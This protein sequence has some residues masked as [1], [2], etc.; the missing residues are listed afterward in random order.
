MSRLSARVLA[1]V[2]LFVSFATAGEISF[3]ED[4]SLAPDRS[5]PLKTLIPGT[6]DFFFFHSLDLQNRQR[7]EDVDAV[8]ASWLKKTRTP[9]ALYREIENR[10]HLL[11]YA[12]DPQRTLTFLRRRL[13]AV[14]SHQRPNPAAQAQLP[15]RLDPQLISVA[16]LTNR[17]L[18]R[19]GSL[20][21]IENAGLE[22]L[23]AA[24]LTDSQRRAWL[25]RLTRPDVP[26]IVRLIV[27]D[28]D[29]PGSRGFGSLAIH[30]RL[31]LKQLDECLTFRR[32]LLNEGIFVSTYI[33]KLRPG[34]DSDWR[35]ERAA[36]TAYLDSLWRFVGRL[37]PVHNSLKAHVLHRRL[38]LDHAHAQHDR[39][40]FLEYLKLPRNMPYV[41]PE[42]LKRLA[43]RRHLANL[44]ANYSAATALPIVGNDE[45]L[46]RAYLQSFFL[47]E[48]NYEVYRP[49]LSDAYLKQLFAETKIVSGQGDPSRWAALLTPE[50]YRRLQQRVDLDF[51]AANTR[52]FAPDDAVAFELDV[53]NVK[54]LIV[55]IFEINS[56]NYYRTQ[57]RELNTDINLDGLVPNFE[58][59]F[60]YREP[61]QR[62]VRR[63]F[64][65]PELEGRGTWVVDFIGNGKS[66]RV[67]VRKGR[68]RHLVRTGSAGHVFTV[69][70][71]A[72]QKLERASLWLGGHEYS[73]GKN[74]TIHV[75]F[76]AAPAK[77]PI[78]LVQDGF[79][80]FDS[81]R[82]ES[83][84]YSFVAGIL[85][86]RESLLNRRKARVVVRPSLSVNGTPVSLNVLTDARLQI[87]STDRD[88]VATTKSVGEFAL[89]DNVESV[90]EF[91]VPSRLSRIDF[92]LTARIKNLSQGKPQAL[93]TGQSFVINAI[94][95]LPRVEDLH[96]AR[97]PGGYLL[98]LRGKTGEPRSSRAIRVVLKHRGF[99]EPV[100]LSMRTDAGGR[101]TLGPLPGIVTV[102]A[103]G[104]D[105]R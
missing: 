43:N 1:S 8:M 7:Y 60:S 25:S 44:Q 30:R 66:S 102:S 104:A 93:A 5:V 29:V 65:F 83:E 45:P 42:V 32:T 77:Q 79:A 51:V 10:Q 63:E 96:L 58:R 68:L 37:D 20:N 80:S 23:A 90:H 82:H 55:K 59:T 94:D 39:A 87:T 40:V 101:V 38:A 14:L 9:T 91:Q 54:T 16:R 36:E 17:V 15:T 52:L 46:I 62:R 13:A 84:G 70:G 2:V 28:L 19:N 61:P 64:K 74:G 92:V 76:S 71:E 35:N 12:E 6:E 85:V 95:Q 41:R 72:G 97:V 31:L 81:F 57:V 73:A 69:L 105:G 50:Q 89:A 27:A 22:R 103:T 24:K 21:G 18:A 26:G 75:P 48:D 53:K 3:L 49:Y 4:F 34:D 11:R 47:R 33:S 67:L 88:G 78:I 98:E 99:R 56:L 86:D 100:Q